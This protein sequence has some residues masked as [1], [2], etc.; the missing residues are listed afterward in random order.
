[1]CDHARACDH[2][3]RRPDDYQLKVRTLRP[4]DKLALASGDYRE[5]L[6]LHDLSGAPRQPITIEGT[7]GTIF[8]ARREG[9]TISIANAS[10]IVLRRLELDGH[11]LPVDAVK[12]ERG[13]I[14]HDVTL[15]N[16]T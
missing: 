8:H 1:M 15:E 9:N 10:Y 12:A 2:V 3:S 5:G 16:L 4:G 14:A 7:R 13:S 6:A 11:D